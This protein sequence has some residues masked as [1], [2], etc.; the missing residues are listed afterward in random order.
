[1]TNETNPLD[2]GRARKR[3]I[4]HPRIQL[5]LALRVL[6][7]WLSCILTM[8]IFRFFLDGPVRLLLSATGDHQL[9]DQWVIY[10]PPFLAS[11]FFVPVILYDIMRLSNRFV[12]PMERLKQGLLNLA[13]GQPVD[14]I[15][16]RQG[17]LWHDFAEAFNAVQT[18]VDQ[19]TG[20]GAGAKT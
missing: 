9:A 19:T 5:Q 18:R 4:C 15:H 14:P 20:P 8:Q 2:Q 10:A 7:Y 6:I 1:M 16:F 12:G 13:D 3:L 11:L 17:D